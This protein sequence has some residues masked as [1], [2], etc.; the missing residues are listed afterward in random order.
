MIIVR[1]FGGL[2]NQLFQYAFAKSLCIKY[3]HKLSIDKSYFNNNYLQRKSNLSQRLFQLDNF[4]TNYDLCPNRISIIGRILSRKKLYY[5][6]NH[7]NKY[8]SNI[9]LVINENNFNCK[10][11]KSTKLV[12]LN[13]YWQS[14]H[15]IKAHRKY[16][17]HD[18]TLKIFKMSDIDKNFYKEILAT[19][20]VSVHFRKGDYIKNPDLR[21]KFI[22]LDSNYYN[23]ATKLMAHKVGSQNIKLFIFSDDIEWVKNN[24][25][26][27]YD[28]VFIDKEV[29]DYMSLFLMSN[30]KHNIIA[31]STFTSISQF[32]GR[33]HH[34]RR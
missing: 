33:P 27:K 30:C 14:D 13:D 10:L 24:M 15:L 28:H 21:S 7:L 4:N 6:S 2:G 5:L 32:S 8:V 19:K 25:F 29:S 12:Y 1:I 16:L 11:I 20:S 22:Q 18:L 34:M 3:N 9:P 17:L 31:N 26:F 23:Q